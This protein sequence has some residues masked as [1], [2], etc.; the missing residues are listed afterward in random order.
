MSL[1]GKIVRV[2]HPLLKP[3]SRI[4]LRKKRSW[5][6][7]ELNLEVMPGIF[8]PGLFFSTKILMDML[9][10]MDLKGKNFLELGCGSGAI[11]CLAASKGAYATASD[12]DLK[13]LENTKS[14]A[15]LNGLQIE[16]VKSDLFNSIQEKFDVIIINPPY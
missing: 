3:I 9:S 15:A 7:K 11:S 10:G 13:A 2:F 4:Y 1:R 16:T 5:K 12:I 6:Y 8:H 14:N